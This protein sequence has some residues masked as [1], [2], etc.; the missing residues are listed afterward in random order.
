MIY[1]MFAV[2]FLTLLIGF[3]AV[4]VRK[5]SV[6]LGEVDP[7]Y[8]RLMQGYEPTEIVVKT[9]RCINNMFEFPVLFYIVCSLYLVLGVENLLGVVIAWLFVLFRAVQAYIHLTY[10]HVIHRMY[11]FGAGVL[12]VAVL[13]VNLLLYMP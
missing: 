8:Y 3:V 11:V 10:N 6:R 9:T 12:C 1:P 7:R 4:K 5:A 2:F 13:W